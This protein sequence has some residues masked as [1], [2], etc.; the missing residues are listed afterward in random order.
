M[1]KIEKCKVAVG[2]PGATTATAATALHTFD[3]LG[4]TKAHIYVLNGSAITTSGNFTDIDI[5][6]GTNSSGTTLISAASWGTATSTAAANL[7]PTDALGGLCGGVVE[8]HLDLRDK[9]RYVSV[10]TKRGTTPAASAT[11]GVFVL[12]EPEES[13]DSTTEKQTA[14]LGINTNVCAVGTVNA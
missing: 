10:Y 5:Y 13:A 12:L 14:N 6:H 1:N 2:L 9:H 4:C 8:I 7:L 3:T 11:G